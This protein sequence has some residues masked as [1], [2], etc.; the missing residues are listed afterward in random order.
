MMDGPVGLEGVFDEQGG[1]VVSGE[2]AARLHAL[3]GRKPQ[4]GERA[5]L[6]LVAVETE[7]L[8]SDPVHAEALERFL[9]T[10]VV[11]SIEE[12]REHP[13]RA[14]S[15]EQIRDYFAAKLAAAQAA[16]RS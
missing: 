8:R 6:A 16:R 13:E 11:A 10:E 2:G 12:L 15:S 3:I 1:F 7:D 4:A 14:Y 5:E 9:R